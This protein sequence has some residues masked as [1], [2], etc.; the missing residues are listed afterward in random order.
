MFLISK[1]DKT[2]FLSGVEPRIKIIVFL[3]LLI[4]NLLYQGFFFSLFLFALS[5]LYIVFYK[6]PI[7]QFFIIFSEAIFIIFIL[8]IIKSLRQGAEVLFSF[9]LYFF[10]FIFYYEG[11]KEGF[12]IGFRI[13]GALSVLYI[14]ILTTSFT[15][16]LSSLSWFRVPKDFIEILFFTNKYI[17]SFLEDAFTIYY[18]QKNRLGYINLRNSLNSM[19]IL[20][21]SLVLKAFE[22]SQT[23]TTAM[24]MRGYNGNIP[25]L[26]S[27]P[28][29]INDF[30]LTAVFISG[31]FIIWLI[32]STIYAR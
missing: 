16:V 7:R 17:K 4:L 1:G 6:F 3:F 27:K 5:F 19:G 30:I 24:V 8:L 28:L 10:N 15:E 32:F 13:F 12:L 22:Q 14:F 29:K 21:G 18:S 2:D 26:P 11:L 23:T 25:F 31:F 9:N 20:A